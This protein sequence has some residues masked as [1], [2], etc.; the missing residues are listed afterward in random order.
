LSPA[1][2][3]RLAEIDAELSRLLEIGF[4][5]SLPAVTEGRKGQPNASAARF[6][7]RPAK[8]EVS[9]VVSEANGVADR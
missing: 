2:L 8:R 6:G 4:G 5:Q 1:V 7:R 3:G 9:L